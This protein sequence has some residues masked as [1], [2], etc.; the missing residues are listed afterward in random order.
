MAVKSPVFLLVFNRPEPTR[1]VFQA[2]REYRPTRLYL[3]ADGPRAE[4]RVNGVSALKLA[5]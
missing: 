3:A 4:K 5:K 1:Q 2:I